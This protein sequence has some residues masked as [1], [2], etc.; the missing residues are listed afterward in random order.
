MNDISCKNLAFWSRIIFLY[1]CGSLF[2]TII[3]SPIINIMLSK[4]RNLTILTIMNYF[5]FFL[6]IFQGIFYCILFIF[7][8]ISYG[9]K[10]K[11]DGGLNTFALIYIIINCIFLSLSILIGCCCGICLG[12]IFVTSIFLSQKS[13]QKQYMPV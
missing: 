8:C 13:K 6:R 1:H 7:F 3:L 9:K 12:G 10:E 11:C 2:L 5:N 4:I